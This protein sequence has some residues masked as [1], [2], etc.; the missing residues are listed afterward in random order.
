MTNK[1]WKISQG[2]WDIGINENWV[3]KSKEEAEEQ[4]RE[5]M[6]LQLDGFEEGSTVEGL[7]AEGGYKIISLVL[8]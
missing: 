8:K 4:L 7:I 3:F 5:C 6:E 1:L 2:E